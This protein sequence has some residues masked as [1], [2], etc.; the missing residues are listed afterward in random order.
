[1]SISFGGIGELSVTFEADSSVKAGWPV[2]I[3]GNGKVSA[4]GDGEKFCGIALGVSKD[5]YATV[6]I[7]GFI[8]CKYTGTG[9]PAL[10]FEHFVADGSG[11][12][13][14]DSG[15]TNTF[16]D[17][18][19]QSVGITRYTGGEYMTAELDKTEKTVGIY[20]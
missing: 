2:K 8:K 5:G 6:Q 7:R 1:M 12:V 10:G 19:S 18:A 13:K 3:S 4:C 16:T 9:V 20:M 15:E 14:K 11:N 17:A